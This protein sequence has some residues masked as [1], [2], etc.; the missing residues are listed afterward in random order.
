MHP[1]LRVVACARALTTGKENPVTDEVVE[2]DGIESQEADDAPATPPAD[3]SATWK[4][5]LAGK[6]RALT[7][8]KAELERLKA[9]HA[10]LSQWK[11]ER[12][13]ADLTEVEKLQRKV[14]ELEQSRAEAA[15][16]ALR[17]EL[18]R[19]FPRAFELLGDRTPLDDEGYL[20]ELETRLTPPSDEPDE[21]RVDPNKPRRS[22][23]PSSKPATTSDELKEQLRSLG[24]P[25]EREW[26]GLN[27]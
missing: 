1:A 15:A 11:A 23:P 25:F 2:N 9:E 3:D 8:A 19:Q 5:R 27:G 20:A 7:N 10:A 24:N 18:S 13:Q 16:K 21:P 22:L 4:A 14:Q 6:D 26:T 12:E 17:A